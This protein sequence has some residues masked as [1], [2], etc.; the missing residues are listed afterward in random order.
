[1]QDAI[2]FFGEAHE[3][4]AAIL[5]MRA[6]HKALCFQPIHEANRAVMADLQPFGKL[7]D[8]GVIATGEAAN[9]EQRLL[10][11]RGNADLARRLFARAQKLADRIAERSQRLILLLA[12]GLHFG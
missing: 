4:E 12:D 3:D 9:R 11:L 7:A 2:A 10:L 5:A 8:A 6:R 1:M